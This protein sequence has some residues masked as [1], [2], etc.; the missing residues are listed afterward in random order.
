MEYTDNKI[1]KDIEG[2]NAP[3]IEVLDSH[4]VC[5]CGC[6]DTI[7]YPDFKGN[8]WTACNKC[9]KEFKNGYLLKAL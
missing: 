8:I 6:D 3:D 9:G 2:I 4:T 1:D 5:M 7:T